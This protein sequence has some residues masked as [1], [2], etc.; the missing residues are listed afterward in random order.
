L[1][2]HI[3]LEQ[4]CSTAVEEGARSCFVWHPLLNHLR[5]PIRLLRARL[6]R[7]RG[8][9]RRYPDRAHTQVI[10]IRVDDGPLTFTA[11]VGQRS[12]GARITR[13]RKSGSRVFDVLAGEMRTVYGATSLFE[14]ESRASKLS[15]GVL[16]GMWRD[17]ESRNPAEKLQ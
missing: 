7:F 6:G 3:D 8:R 13:L 5:D 9:F 1:D 16:P 10:L 14:P 11:L 15:S 17:G 12:V 4:S 2:A